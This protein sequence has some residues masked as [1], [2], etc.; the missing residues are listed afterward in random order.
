MVVLSSNLSLQ[1]FL[2]LPVLNVL[3]DLQITPTDIFSWLKLLGLTH[4]SR[5]NEPRSRS[6]PKA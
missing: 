4:K 5:N 3:A 2:E 1:E 6:V